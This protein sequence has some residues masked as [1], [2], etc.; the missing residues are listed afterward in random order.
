M[1]VEGISTEQQQNTPPQ[2]VAEMTAWGIDS[3]TLRVTT[4]DTLSVKWS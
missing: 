1:V 4:T 3:Q 2:R